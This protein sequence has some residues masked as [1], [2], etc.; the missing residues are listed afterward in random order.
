MKKRHLQG[1][2]GRRK[3]TLKE[4]LKSNFS[5][6]SEKNLPGTPQHGPSTRGTVRAA[7]AQPGTCVGL[8]RTGQHPWAPRRGQAT[9]ATAPRLP[10]HPWHSHP[11]ATP[12]PTG[13]SVP[14]HAAPCRAVLCRAAAP[15]PASPSP[16]A[17]PSP[18][19]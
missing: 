19:C 5:S 2:K 4:A 18:P 6:S 9:V 16:A 12:V 14:R 10:A 15:V 7:P 8:G 13:C 1:M 17:Q 11:K 3:N